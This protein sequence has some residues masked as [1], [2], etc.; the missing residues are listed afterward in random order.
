MYD[1]NGRQAT[2]P[3][4]TKSSFILGDFRYEEPLTSSISQLEIP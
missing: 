1:I 2:L 3:L 4:T